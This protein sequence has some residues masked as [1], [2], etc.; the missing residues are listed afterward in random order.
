MAIDLA[1]LDARLHKDRRVVWHESIG[2]TMVEA[3]RLAAEGWASGTVVG[4]EEQ[5]AGQGRMGRI[6]HS[7]KGL[8][9]YFTVI[10]RLPL[11]PQHLPVLTLALG[12][13]VSDT[14]RLL[15][16]TPCD[17]RWPNDLLVDG[18][19]CAGILTQ[20]QGSAVLAGIGLNVNQAEFP[21]DV[22]HVAT[23]LALATGKQHRREPL[24]V[25]LLG[26]ID[27]FA[28]VLTTSGVEPI[29]QMFE[30]CSSYVRGRRVVVDEAGGPVEGVTE[31]LTP[32]GFLQLRKDDGALV[33]ILAGGVRPARG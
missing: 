8:G 27:S 12:L 29:L 26:A 32:A 10:L 7:E 30:N 14:V 11:A 3:A 2:S 19:K 31:G 5:T 4:A 24:L 15:G 18:K 20:L 1:F 23:S 6:W 21:E 28:R 33:T 9:L 22:A 25:Y 17:L 13:A 16:G